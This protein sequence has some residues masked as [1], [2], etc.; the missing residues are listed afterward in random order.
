MR[1]GLLTLVVPTLALGGGLLFPD[2]T[3]SIVV[4]AAIVHLAA[5]LWHVLPDPELEQPP[6]ME[7]IAPPN[8]RRP[9]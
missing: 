5:G 8:V 3:V 7:P 4:L 1:I 6:Q 2:F 9:E